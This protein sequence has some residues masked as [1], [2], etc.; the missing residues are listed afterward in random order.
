MQNQAV[1]I[2]RRRGNYYIV[3]VLSGQKPEIRRSAPD[4]CGPLG[5]VRL[6]PE[7]AAKRIAQRFG[8]S[9]SVLAD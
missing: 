3:R 5:E 8:N 1:V 7:D 4:F 6:T 9:L 2:P